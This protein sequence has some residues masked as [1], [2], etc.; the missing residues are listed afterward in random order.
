DFRLVQ[1]PTQGLEHRELKMRIPA[2]GID[3]D[4]SPQL[5]DAFGYHSAEQPERA[6]Q[7]LV[8]VVVVRLEALGGFERGN[9]LI[10]LAQLQVDAPEPDVRIGQPWLQLDRTRQMVERLLPE[11]ANAHAQAFPVARGA[12]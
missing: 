10:D 11:V 6:C 1:M 2:L 12:Q 3:R 9:R 5:G 4:R 8:N 7:R